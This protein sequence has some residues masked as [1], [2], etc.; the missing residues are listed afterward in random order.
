M[1]RAAGAAAL[2]RAERVADRPPPRAP[3]LE[4]R[5]IDRLRLMGD[6]R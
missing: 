6:A 4:H 1:D 3:G 2:E 5:L